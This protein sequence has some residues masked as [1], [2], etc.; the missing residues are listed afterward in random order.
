VALVGVHL[1]GG[2]YGWLGLG[3]AS[4]LA[5]RVEEC[6]D[7]VGEQF[8]DTWTWDG[9]TWTQQRPATSPPARFDG[10]MAYDVITGTAVLFG[11]TDSAGSLLGD[12]WT[13]NGTNWKQGARGQPACPVPGDD[14]L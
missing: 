3:D 4:R 5:H 7:V 2:R 6:A 11:G 14:G 12:T 1:I 13:W 8:G 10:A 9:T